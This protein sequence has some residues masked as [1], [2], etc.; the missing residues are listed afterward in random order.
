MIAMCVCHFD[1]TNS[2]GGLEK[3]A[4]LLSRTLQARGEEVVILTSTRKYSRA[5]WQE[6]NGL[7][8]RFFWTYTT[9]QVSGKKL[10]A[11]LIWALQLFL[12]VMF[13][14]KLIT[15]FHSHQIR[16]HAF[17]GAL[18]QQLWDIPHI[19]KSATGGAGA[20]IK[21]IG[22]HKYFGA[23]GRRY[24]IRN[25]RIF[26]A[27]TETIA[28]DLRNYDVPE[29]SIRVIPNGL[30]IPDQITV[31]PNEQRWR[32]ALFM[33]RIEEDKNIIAFA[34][35]ALR[36]ANRPGG[37]VDIYG[38]GS[39]VG[40]L[41]MLLSKYPHSVVRYRGFSSDIL[42]V[43]SGYGWTFLPSSAEGLSNAMLE[44]MACGV[45]PI[46]T[47]VSGCV[48]HIKPGENGFFFEGLDDE[49]LA[50]GIKQAAN[51]R[52]EQWQAMSAAARLHAERHFSL[53]AVSADY[54]AVYQ[55]LAAVGVQRI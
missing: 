55:E 14:R 5:G 44:A 27:T 47:R 21:T 49:S 33:G 3:Q 17:V 39:L 40:E 8:V 24:L 13:N 54:V 50:R 38:S 46:T 32:Q 16:I 9:P 6:I 45:V 28:Q 19:L 11:S 23:R 31:A 29:E 7:R 37:S 41:E 48:D 12:W 52:Y 30:H 36:Q 42:Q 18:V 35:A 43:L 51:T 34:R 25:T 53:E 1:D 22:S 20:D 4:E 26:I 10:P 2:C 15:A